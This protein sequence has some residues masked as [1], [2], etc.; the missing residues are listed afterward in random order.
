MASTWGLYRG[1]IGICW[2]ME[3]TVETTIREKQLEDQ[4]E[5]AK[6]TLRYDRERGFGV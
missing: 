3:K 1:Y 2:G 4:M 6:E 5:H